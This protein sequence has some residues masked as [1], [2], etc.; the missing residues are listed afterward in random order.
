MNV[1]KKNWCY[2]SCSW[3]NSLSFAAVFSLR[4]FSVDIHSRFSQIFLLKEEMQTKEGNDL[5]VVILSIIIKNCILR[6]FFYFQFIV[7]GTFAF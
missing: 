7:N 5:G 6:S 2:Y 3:L 1:D 4:S